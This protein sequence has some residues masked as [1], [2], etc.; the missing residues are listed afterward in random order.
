MVEFFKS[1]EKH[2]K[3]TQKNIKT[4][5]SD[6]KFHAEHDSVVRKKY[7]NR[8]KPKKWKTH[9]FLEKCITEKPTNLVV[10]FFYTFTL[11][12]YSYHFTHLGTQ[13]YNF[14]TQNYTITCT[15]NK[16]YLMVH[17]IRCT[18]YILSAQ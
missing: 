17:S 5:I 9:V 7:K 16:V 2:Q 1:H 15:I 8:G 13:I 3:M 14:Y 18:T 11:R 10:V 6:V 12:S 4:Y